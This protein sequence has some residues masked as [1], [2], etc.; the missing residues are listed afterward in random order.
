VDFAAGDS[1]LITSIF[2][3]SEDTQSQKNKKV[4]EPPAQTD[5]S[6]QGSSGDKAADGNTTATTQNQDSQNPDHSHDGEE[7]EWVWED[8]EVPDHFRRV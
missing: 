3:M 2:T 4:N 7:G 1:F 6:S 5:A 8:P